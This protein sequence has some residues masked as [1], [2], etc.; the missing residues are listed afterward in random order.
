MAICVNLWLYWKYQWLNAALSIFNEMAISQLEELSTIEKLKASV[1]EDDSGSKYQAEEA[2]GSEYS[3]GWLSALNG[4]GYPVMMTP[5]AS[6]GCG[7][8]NGY[9]SC[10][11]LWKYA[12]WQYHSHV[13]ADCG[14][15]SWHFHM[16]MA[17]KKKGEKSGRL[18]RRMRI[19]L[20][21]HQPAISCQCLCSWLIGLAGPA[22]WLASVANHSA[23]QKSA[24][25][26]TK[27]PQS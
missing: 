5:S 18:L 4:L 13:L 11:L 16:K 21:L 14:S 2:L 26:L 7:L 12:I 25:K 1:C 3:G 10:C 24:R 8:C 23:G 19:W 6:A 15:C 27:W 9:L 22:M 17:L 20:F